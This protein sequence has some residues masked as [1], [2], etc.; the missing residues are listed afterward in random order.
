MIKNPNNGENFFV[1]LEIFTSPDGKMANIAQGHVGNGAQWFCA[2]CS[3]SSKDLQSSPL[4]IW[5]ETTTAV[6][7]SIS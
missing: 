1:P 5:E 2:H 6:S 4:T 7:K 3:V